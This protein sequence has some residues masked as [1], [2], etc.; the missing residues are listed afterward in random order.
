[1]RENE[2]IVGFHLCDDY[3]QICYCTDQTP[4]P[5]SLNI[6]IKRQG[7]AHYENHPYAQQNYLIPTIIGRNK[8]TKEWIFGEE[9]SR[10][11]KAGK[12]IS[13]TQLLRKIRTGEK[14][15]IYGSVYTPEFLL[16]KFLYKGLML[17]KKKFPEKKIKKIVVSVE[18]SKEQVVEAIYKAL[19]NLGI[20]RDRAVVQSQSQSYIY[21][22]LSQKKEL[23]TN[24]VA[25]F[26]FSEKGVTYY[27]ISIRRRKTPYIVEVFQKDFSHILNY[28]ILEKVRTER[29]LEYILDNIINDALYNQIVST[30]Y[31]TGKGFMRD[32]PEGIM[33]YICKGR[34]LFI[35][36][37]LY[38]M[39][40]CYAARELAGEKDFKEF[41][42]LSEESLKFSVS[43]TAYDDGIEKELPL[44]EVG[45]PIYE[46]GYPVDF[47][48]DDERII[49]FTI[50]DKY[51]IKVIED[52]ITIEELPKRPNKTTRIEIRLTFLNHSTLVLHIRDKGFGEFYPATNKVWEKEVIIHG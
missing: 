18:I 49:H 35:G 52:N 40:A 42:F 38:C 17:L 45:T 43:V 21:Y 8:D 50:R 44:V 28:E 14:V 36:Q 7:T 30:I 39:G 34:R 2:L 32:L 20:K 31:F 22:A 46:A 48:L 4:E 27:Q 25:L 11:H 13:V 51:G 19:D 9:G 33:K 24:D 41:I 1:M 15:D 37:N 6:D 26:D 47:I 5:D 23:W 10:Q 16:E 3:S 29:N 12:A